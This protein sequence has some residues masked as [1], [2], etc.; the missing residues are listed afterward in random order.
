MGSVCSIN[1]LSLKTNKQT[2]ACSYHLDTVSLLGSR[3]VRG[4]TEHS[5]GAYFLLADY[6]CLG[7]F[8]FTQ[9]SASP[10]AQHASYFLFLPNQFR[11]TLDTP[12][13]FDHFWGFLENQAQY[14]EKCEH[15]DEGKTQ[16]KGRVG[17][18]CK[19]SETVAA[20]SWVTGEAGLRTLHA[21]ALPS[22]LAKKL[23]SLNRYF[24]KLPVSLPATGWYW[25]SLF[26]E[27][28]GLF[29]T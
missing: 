10:W 24:H 29:L 23:L 25:P 9:F 26:L 3:D 21:F 15:L 12:T 16:M 27:N 20:F 17:S 4:I 7:E 8:S 14:S 22:L 1:I 11:R 18:P 19:I 6:S 2:K 28:I 5:R 13:M